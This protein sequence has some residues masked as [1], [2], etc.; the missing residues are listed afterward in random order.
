MTISVSPKVK[1]V[2]M[3]TNGTNTTYNPNK[4]P[5]DA[6]IFP[7]PIDSLNKLLSFKDSHIFNITKN[8]AIFDQKGKYTTIQSMNKESANSH[9]ISPITKTFN[10]VMCDHMIKHDIEVNVLKTDIRHLS[11]LNL[12]HPKEVKRI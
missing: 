8:Q 10:N 9:S 3:T 12:N 4:I 5:H 6:E 7:L 1:I 2:N 11:P